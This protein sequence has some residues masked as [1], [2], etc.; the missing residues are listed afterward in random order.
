M[1]DSVG[2]PSSDD[3]HEVKTLVLRVGDVAML[4][5]DKW[6]VER[7]DPPEKSKPHPIQISEAKFAEQ[8]GSF[9][10]LGLPGRVFAE[11]KPPPS[12]GK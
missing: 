12:D 1:R 9:G 2:S 4:P 11:T 6:R 7:D 5:C 3:V 8:A 10:F